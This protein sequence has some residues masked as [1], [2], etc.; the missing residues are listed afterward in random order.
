MLWFFR[1]LSGFLSVEFSG[2][3]S[4]IILNICAKNGIY[5]WAIKRRKGKII[6]NMSVRDFRLLP[7]YIKGQGIRVHIL[8][9]YGF[10]FIMFRYKKRWG[11]PAGVLLFF[12][13]LK[14]MSLF[15]WTVEVNGNKIVETNKI[16]SAI[17]EIGIEEGS[18]KSKI[19]PQKAK[20]KLLLKVD[21][22]SWATLNIE[23]CRVNVEVIEGENK[24]DN[25]NTATDLIS[26]SDGIIKKIDIVSG[27]CVV[28]VGDTVTKGDL[29]VSGILERESETELVNS[30]GKIIA[31]IEREI[32]LEA[33]YKQ[34]ISVKTGETNIKRAISFF[35]LD[36]PLYLGSE[37]GTFE[38][39]GSVK[40]LKLL[41]E[42][43]PIRIYTANFEKNIKQNKK[44]TRKELE[45][46]L[47]D[48]LFK[49]LEV[50]KI[51]DF[52]IKNREYD[53]IE[54]GISLKATVSAKKNIVE[55][56][57][58]LFNTRN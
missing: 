13:F 27:N 20:Q 42:K 8:K 22:L 25:K 33:Y 3:V 38:S 43:L 40:Q 11:I 14:I 19:N 47:E 5:L 39:Y 44:Y 36:V 21:G 23:G 30:V 7:V 34:N 58:L 35:N 2:D 55:K 32:V 51:T 41:G 31:D 46:Q 48:S 49:K 28:K 45:K 9:K 15:V 24:S 56:K 4:E 6:C 18:L 12:C 50:E 37:K 29:L 10:P 54:G 26:D 57:I 1:F 17:Q 53:E 52:S 16:I